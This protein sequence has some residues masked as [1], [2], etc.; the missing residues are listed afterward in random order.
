MILFT[1]YEPAP[2]VE[3][4]LFFPEPPSRWTAHPRSVNAFWQLRRRPVD[5]L[6]ILSATLKIEN[7]EWLE[8]VPTKNTF[9]CE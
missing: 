4:F 6:T 5:N 7:A 8:W 9:L 2:G 1:R 3:F